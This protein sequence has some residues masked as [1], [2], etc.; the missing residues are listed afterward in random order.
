MN[1]ETS[2]QTTNENQTNQN[3]VENKKK[4]VGDK[5]FTPEE[6]ERYNKKQAEKTFYRVFFPNSNKVLHTHRWMKSDP[7]KNRQD[8]FVLSVVDSN[9]RG[10]TVKFGRTVFI[11]D[12]KNRSTLLNPNDPADQALIESHYQTAEKRFNKV[13]KDQNYNHIKLP[14]P[15]WNPKGQPTVHSLEKA[16]LKKNHESLMSTPLNFAF[17]KWVENQ[18]DFEVWKEDLIARMR[19]QMVVHPLPTTPGSKPKSSSVSAK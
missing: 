19:S 11:P 15:T 14:A 8:F 1:P 16:D 12:N 18:P 2:T 9:K 6:I 3:Q 4:T 5:V 10:M 13:W 7:E 17:L